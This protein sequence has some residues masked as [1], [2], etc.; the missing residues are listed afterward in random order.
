[1]QVS[2][3]CKVFVNNLSAN[4][5]L[6]KTQL[7]KIRQSRGFLVRLLETLLKSGLLLMKN[8]LKPLPKRVLIP[9][10]SPAAV[11]TADAGISKKNIGLGVTT[12]IISN[13]EMDDIMKIVKSLKEAN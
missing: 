1:M 8:V 13:A 12:L 4:I 7:S 9:L 6:S 10:G 11:S 2:K 5:K 3:L